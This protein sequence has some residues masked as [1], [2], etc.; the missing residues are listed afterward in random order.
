MLGRTQCLL[1]SNIDDT[2][3]SS[4]QRL[5]TP[6]LNYVIINLSEEMSYRKEAEHLN[7]IQHRDKSTCFNP[8]TLSNFIINCG[9]QAHQIQLNQAEQVLY[10]F[11]FDPKTGALQPG[12]T[13]PSSITDP[14]IPAD[15]MAKAKAQFQDALNDYM[16]KYP[17]TPL[18]IPEVLSKLECPQHS[19]ILMIDD[20]SVKRQKEERSVNG[21]EGKK[22]AQTVINTIC[23]I[24]S[25]EGAYAIAAEDT[26]QGLIMSL[27][28][29]LKNNLLENH[30]LIIFFDGAKVIRT[31]VE[32]I[33]S[34]H[35]PLAFYLDWYHVCKRISENLSMGLKC[36]K[37]NRENNQDLIKRILK[38]IWFN[39]IDKAVDI[40]T[41]IESQMIRNRK[42]II[43]TIDY[44]NNRRP[45]LY[46]FASRKIT[47]LINSSNRVEDMNNQIVAR[48]QKNKGMSWSSRGSRG[49][50]VVC[51]L[52][53][54]N[55][56]DVWI[57]QGT[58][59][60]SPKTG[61][62]DTLT[63]A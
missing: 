37:E 25:S 19:T 8:I 56:S 61:K 44:L 22:S 33:F 6:E 16:Q 23:W 42:K 1:S 39:Q 57:S 28:Y 20:V 41:S 54:N 26:K 51:T 29:M 11:G 17:D 35:K 4:R 12:V 45:Y 38:K 58:I 2:G 59:R 31:N 50:A 53:V 52:K 27:G 46:N 13:L 10:E 21:K 5:Y 49:L 32:E 63:A 9:S 3:L 55:E 62:Q 15:E 47:G 30:N 36:G 24:V 34:F 48:R 40:L 60:F 43:D 14:V 18:D 7:Q